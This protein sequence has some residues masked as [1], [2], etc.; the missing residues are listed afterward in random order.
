MAVPAGYA[1]SNRH[2]GEHI[3]LNTPGPAVQRLLLMAPL[4]LI[5]STRVTVAGVDASTLGVNVKECLSWKVNGVHPRNP[6]RGVLWLDDS[7][8]RALVGFA[9]SR[10]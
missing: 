1:S 7:L 3:E 2:R 6:W 4:K 5:Q 10:N 9:V 8:A